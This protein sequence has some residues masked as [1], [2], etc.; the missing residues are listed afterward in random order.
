MLES[1]LEG[2]LEWS[3]KSDGARELG[4]RGNGEER[5]IQDWVG[6]GQ[7]RWPDDHENERKSATNRGNVVAIFRKKQ[8]PGIR[9]V[10]KNQ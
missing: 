3:W 10:P 4:G 2:G 7:G 8:R 5:E 1:H 9:E 6:E